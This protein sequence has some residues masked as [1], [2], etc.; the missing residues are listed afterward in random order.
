MRNF[1]K[2]HVAALS[3]AAGILSASVAPFLVHAQQAF[4]VVPTTTASS[5]T[6]D[7]GAQFAD[8]GTLLVIGLA[9]GIP[10][11]FYVIHQ[12]IGLLP[13]SRGRRN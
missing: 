4:A 10:L 5:L 6:A 13:K 3:T 11:T 1:M 2:K 7:I 9:A 8:P 12:L